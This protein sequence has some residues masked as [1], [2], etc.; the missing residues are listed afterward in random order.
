MNTFTA[1][2][3]SP[4]ELEE[5]RKEGPSVVKTKVEL[6]D[7][8]LCNM[9]VCYYM[10]QDLKEME[11]Y[12]KKS[13]ELY[14]DLWMRSGRTGSNAKHSLAGIWR[15][16]VRRRRIISK[17]PGVGRNESRC[18]PYLGSVLYSEEEGGRYSLGKGAGAGGG[19]LPGCTD[20]RLLSRPFQ[21]RRK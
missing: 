19:R 2:Y 17:N 5:G 15:E 12:A 13:R 3:T 7:T 10:K 14:L 21:G 8:F 6:G 11:T 20:C 18:A 9:Y 1:C 4:T 16:M